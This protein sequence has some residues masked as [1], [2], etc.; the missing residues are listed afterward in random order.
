MTPPDS[1]VEPPST[2]QHAREVEAGARFE[3]G[4]NWR[5]FLNELDEDRVAEAE[6]SLRKMLNSQDLKGLRFLDVG[7]GSGLFSLA[8]AR[9]GAGRV[10]SFDFDPASVGCAEE[11]R[12]RWAPSDAGS[13]SIERGSVLDVDYLRGLGQWDV[14]Y[15]WGVLHHT[16]QMEDA[17]ANAGSLVA[18]EGRL[19]I[20]IYNDQ[21][22]PSRMW[23]RVKRL[24][25]ALPSALRKPFVV[26]VV[27]PRELAA[28]S[29]ELL[30]LRPGRYL[31]RWRDYKRD[32]GMSLW[33]D[34]VDWVGGYPF[35]VAS[36]QE[37]FDFYRVRGFRLDRMTT[38]QG[39]GCNE[40]VFTRTGDEPG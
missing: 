13:W 33:H 22:R 30:K 27:A 6:A 25:N 12:R 40:Y 15:S 32:R 4:E 18:P 34:M 35:E 37:I 29:R 21:G 23:R 10:H 14:V 7:C 1:A 3:F 38:Q 36:P 39:L 28:A 2:D 19:F 20:A 31:D 11:L 8:A 9:L 17:L 26:M 16:G 24:Y 5:R